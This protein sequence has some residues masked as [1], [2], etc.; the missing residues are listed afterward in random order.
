MNKINYLRVI[1]PH[2]GVYAGKTRLAAVLDDAAR[3]ELNRWLL[4]RTLRI[5]AGWLGDA[6]HCTVVSPCAS[7]LAL[8]RHAGANTVTEPEPAL[9]LNAALVHGAGHAVTNGAQQLLILPCDLPCL[10][11]AALDAMAALAAPGGDVV[12]APDR[13]GSGTNAMLVP[14][15]GCEFAFGAG[16][17]ARHIAMADARGMRVRLCN[18]SALAFDLD[19][20]A[21]FAEW[22]KSAAEKPPFLAPRQA[23]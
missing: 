5:V 18:A 3:S 1:I 4:A 19:T 23:A 8:A 21:D 15:T 11:A 17:L 2:R 10:D 13:H 9:G 22:S 14:A 12:I 7:T 20:A 6:R 16:S